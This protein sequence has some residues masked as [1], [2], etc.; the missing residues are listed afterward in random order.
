M[1]LSR[2]IDLLLGSHWLR[3]SKEGGWKVDQRGGAERWEGGLDRGQDGVF[4]LRGRLQRG[5][6]C[7]GG[8]GGMQDGTHAHYSVKV[9]VKWEGSLKRLSGERQQKSEALMSKRST[10]LVATQLCLNLTNSLFAV[11]LNESKFKKKTN[12]RAIFSV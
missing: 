2:A 6:F 4:V 7:R 8:L 3:E 10:I 5:E 12:T 11:C 1:C 9:L